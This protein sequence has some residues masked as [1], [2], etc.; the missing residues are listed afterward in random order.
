MAGNVPAM[1]TAR[2]TGV[3]V[4]V[5]RTVADHVHCR[6]RREPTAAGFHVVDGAVRRLD[7]FDESAVAI[8]TNRHYFLSPCSHKFVAPVTPMGRHLRIVTNTYVRY[9]L[10]ETY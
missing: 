9:G 10:Y 2:G 5:I 3:V 8:G 4:G 6:P 1:M 7:L